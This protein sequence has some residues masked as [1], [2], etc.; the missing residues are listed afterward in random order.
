MIARICKRGIAV[1]GVAVFAILALYAGRYTVF[2]G[3]DNIYI[4]NHDQIGENLLCFA[5]VVCLLF[6]IRKL[7][8]RVFLKRIIH[9]LAVILAGVVFYI[10]HLLIQNA[11]FIPITDSMQIYYSVQALA[12]GAAPEFVSMGRSYFIVFP[13]QLSL[14]CLYAL[15]LRTVNIAATVRNIE[16]VQAM[17]AALAV[18]AGYRIVREIFDDL[19]AEIVYLLLVSGCIPM[20]IFAMYIYGETVGTSASLIAIWLFLGGNREEGSR[21]GRVLYFLGAMFFIVVACIARGALL[22]VWIAMAI[23]QGILFLRRKEVVPL[24]LV[25]LMLPAILLGQAGLQHLA[26]DWVYG[27]VGSGSPKIMWIAMGLQENEDNYFGPGSYNGFND[28]TFIDSGYDADLVKQEAKDVIGSRF[29]NDFSHPAYAV[30]FFKRKILC[31]WNEPTYSSFFRTFYM[32]DRSETVDNIYFDEVI[33]GRVLRF[34]DRYQFVVY[35]AVFFF[36]VYLLGGR[37]E[38]KVYLIGLIMIGGF[39]LSLIWESSS[40]YIYPYF[41]MALPG[42]AVGMRACIGMLEEIWGKRIRNKR[43]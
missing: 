15:I 36:F 26:E 6:L 28:L 19:H 43:A 11:E 18:Y 37:V 24:L 20:Y 14:S 5:G 10:C 32:A 7:P 22:V 29:Q 39:C 40:R 35:L 34:T 31:Q 23:M 13:Y 1:I 9:F 30:S 27:D 42:A 17:F 3:Y 12:D 41:V 8:D 4:N 25:F 16:Y 38:E 33:H 21:S 2:K